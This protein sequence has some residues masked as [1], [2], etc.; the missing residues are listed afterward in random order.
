MFLGKY[1]RNRQENRVYYSAT[2]PL[3]ILGVDPG[4][5]QD[6]SKCLNFYRR[7]AKLL[8]LWKLMVDKKAAFKCCMYFK[9]GKEI[10]MEWCNTKL[11]WFHGC[12]WS[13][14]QI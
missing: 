5:R 6:T 3:K 2:D 7:S 12:R 14:A 4:R 1:L 11:S 9:S 8:D 13:L 10:K